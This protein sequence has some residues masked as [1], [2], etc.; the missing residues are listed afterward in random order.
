VTWDF[1]DGSPAS[2]TTNPL[3]QYAGPGNYN[4]TVVASGGNGTVTK[5][6]TITI[7]AIPVAGSAIADVTVCGAA[8]LTYNLLQHDGALL[9]SQSSSDYGVAYFPSLTDANAHVNLL[10]P[11]LN[12][13]LGTTAVFAKVYSLANRS[14]FAVTNFSIVLL[15]SPTASVPA[16]LMVCDDTANDNIAT[17]NLAANTAAILAGQNAAAYTV[18]YHLSQNDADTGNAPLSLSYQ[19]TSNPQTIY[20]RVQN[21]LNASCYVT[22]SFRIGLY[23]MPV[24]HQAPD[25]YICDP[26]ENG[27]GLFD[28]MQQTA[29][30]LGNQTASDFN[31]TYHANQADANSGD[32]ALDTNFTNVMNPQ[33]VYIRIENK[34][35]KECFS[36]T[37]FKVEVKPKPNLDMEDNYSLCEGHPI[38]II[39]P[40]GFTGY[41]WSDGTSGPSATFAAAGDYFLTV[42]KDYGPIMCSATKNFS[43]SISGIPTITGIE[44]SDWTSDHN[45]ITVQAAG[46]GEYE[47][48]LDGIHFQ[49]S[50]VFDNLGSGQY[51]VYVND[52]KGCGSVSD[53]VYLL[54]YPKFFTPNGDGINDTWQ[55][56]FSQVEPNMELVIFDRY[57]KLITKFQSTD[58]WDGMVKGIP[59]VADDYWFSI[60]RENGKV[61]RGHFSLKR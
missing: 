50:N 22:T 56:K 25:L 13:A 26:G 5:S 1:G 41:D 49:A 7:S 59:V 44:T 53:D 43:I 24:A 57:G 20:A 28:L 10:S 14:C 47:Y 27:I 30:M 37:T 46:L 2:N 23:E 4:V 18:S 11:N 33:M 8:G 19:N 29:V 36:T 6:K 15:Q 52:K 51:T 35:H 45:I 34:N 38:T 3:H 17:F 61:C 60:K 32:S 58:Y 39:A 31:V 21:N 40:Q 12:L 42:T 9:G 55:I 54:M 48:S 16:D